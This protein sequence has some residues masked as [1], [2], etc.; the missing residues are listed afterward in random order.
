[1]FQCELPL[2]VFYESCLGSARDAGYYVVLCLVAREGDSPSV[3]AEITKF[4]TSLHDLTGERVLFVFA[5]ADPEVSRRG[6]VSA[7]REP[8]WFSS[9]GIAVEGS[10]RLKF[11]RNPRTY[12]IAIDS[13]ERLRNAAA[14]GENQ[15]LQI[16]ELRQAIGLRESS[17]PCLHLTFMH[18]G[19]TRTLPLE[20]GGVYKMIRHLMTAWE[21]MTTELDAVEAQEASVIA[22]LR[23]LQSP[24]DRRRRRLAEAKREIRSLIRKRGAGTDQANSLQELLDIAGSEPGAESR[25][26]YVRAMN[27]IRESDAE[28][29][30]DHRG[31]IMRTMDLWTYE[32]VVV[33]PSRLLSLDRELKELQSQRRSIQIRMVEASDS[34]RKHLTTLRSKGG[35]PRFQRGAL[36][37]IAIVGGMLAL[38]SFLDALTNAF[39][40]VTVPVAVVGTA[41]FTIATGAVDIICRRHGIRWRERETTIT[42]RRLGSKWWL[43]LSGAVLLLWLPTLVSTLSPTRIPSVPD[44]SDAPQQTTAKDR[45]EIL[46]EFGPRIDDKSVRFSERSLSLAECIDAGIFRD[47]VAFEKASELLVDAPV[48]PDERRVAFPQ[49]VD[50]LAPFASDH[51]YFIAT[52]FSWSKDFGPHDQSDEAYSNQSAAEFWWHVFQRAFEDSPD[53]MMAAVAELPVSHQHFRATY[54]LCA[55]LPESVRTQMRSHASPKVRGLAAVSDAARDHS[56]SAALE[57]IRNL[58]QVESENELPVAAQLLRLAVQEA[59]ADPLLAEQSLLIVSRDRSVV[60]H[61]A[62]VDPEGPRGRADRL[63]AAADYVVWAI[64]FEVVAE[65]MEQDLLAEATRYAAVLRDKGDQWPEFGNGDVYARTCA[66]AMLNMNQAM[67][68]A[69]TPVRERV[70]PEIMSA[71]TQLRSLPAGLLDR[72]NMAF[73]TR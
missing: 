13:D 48:D 17:V 7:R 10:H 21:P 63:H 40:L 69:D 4:W 53:Q 64:A 62:T 47:T 2:A 18:D 55:N 11:A 23:R 70:S 60:P 33:S 25:M 24:Q 37:V 1:M 29:W 44:V 22:E 61:Q 50:S 66:R 31:A 46:R 42:V 9:N 26:R 58:V 45:L 38:G 59:I 15:S 54:G 72:V 8:V 57:T 41:V 6:G 36:T 32:G 67:H 39:S 28:A 52:R 71:L 65:P 56:D 5:G 34:S 16:S 73:L 14:L 43:S 30:R 12:E 3:Y 68:G 20:S 27:L 35:R 49:M 51:L 19:T